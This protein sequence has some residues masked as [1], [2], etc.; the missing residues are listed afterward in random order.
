MSDKQKKILFVVTKPYFGGRQRY[1]YDIATNLNRIR[2]DVHV[3][4]GGEGEFN[5]KLAK[6]RIPVHRIRGLG[7][8]VIVISDI[9]AFFSLARIIFTQKPDILHLNSTRTG[10]LGAILARLLNGWQMLRHMDHTHGTRIVFTAHGWAFTEERS[11][12]ATLLIRFAQWLTVVLTHVTVAVS[13][14]T[15]RHMHRALFVRDKIR[16][17]H[18]G[19]AAHVLKHRTVARKILFP[20]GVP[21]SAKGATWVGTVAELSPNKGIGT[22]INAIAHMKNEHPHQKLIFV[23]VGANHGE[24][25]HLR[26][27]IKTHE[28]QDSVFLVGDRK[29]ARELLSAFDIFALTSTKEG[30][31]FVLLEAGVA[32]LPVL[33]SAVGGV[34]ELIS[35]MESGILTQ[36][37]NSKEVAR[38]LEYYLTNKNSR[39]A[40]AAVLAHTVRNHF[41]L[42]SM[43]VKTRKLYED[44]LDS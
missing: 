25:H 20:D 11:S 33:A 32:G 29:D 17:V 38:A 9:V 6:E 34:N 21:E 13:N 8:H 19:T 4:F 3:A 2:F 35:D 27:L 16:I 40:H 1:I 42:E 12:V 14:D 24:E 26:R 43:V 7:R 5:E 23:V 28:L 18:N 31:P 41:N 15:K 30:F 22:T 10:I 36:P 44:P 37:H 39:Q